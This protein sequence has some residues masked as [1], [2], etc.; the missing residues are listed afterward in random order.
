MHGHPATDSAD[1]LVGFGTSDDAGVFRLPARPRPGEALVQ[2]VDFF[3]PIVDEAYDWGRIAAANALSDVYA[4]GGRPLTALQLVGWPR[5]ELPFSLLGEVIR[6]GADVMALAGCTVV[7]GHSI[8]TREPTYGFS[9]TG[10]VTEDEVVAN[11]GARPGDVLVLTKPLGTGI[12]ATAIKRGACPVELRDRAVE[13]MATLNAPGADAAAAV[14]VHAG[15][16]VTG[17][18]LLG[19]L[20]EVLLASRVAAT[21]D[22]DAVPVLAGVGELLEAG[23]FPGGSARN[24][25]AVRA[26]VTGPRADEEAV[27]ILSDAQTSGG[28]LLAVPEDRADALVAELE[29]RG[30]LAAAVVGR[31]DTGEPGAVR[32]V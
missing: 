25:D 2:T 19:H 17:F 10:L 21:V 14:G 20:R 15:T 9:V 16:D 6:G 7:G 4:M 24:V 12:V 29:A 26:A 8:D 27:R 31:V 3:T 11:A 30:S 18:G 13:V 22:V 1:L 5:D 32:L 28:L 23:M